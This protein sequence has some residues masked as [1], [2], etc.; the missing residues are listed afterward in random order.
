MCLTFEKD[1]D[2]K[3]DR[4]ASDDDVEEGDADDSNP[5]TLGGGPRGFM[6]SGSSDCS[7]CVWD[8]RLGAVIDQDAL[9]MDSGQTSFCSADEGDREVTAEVRQVLKGHIGG[10]LDLRID[11]R[12][13]VSW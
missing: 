4:D 11:Q 2:R 1:W 8:L 6:V 3:G 10:V 13:I 9:S 12:W 7:I 5:S